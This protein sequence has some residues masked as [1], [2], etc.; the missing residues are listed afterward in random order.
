MYVLL[1]LYAIEQFESK[2][3]NDTV[4]VPWGFPN[5]ESRH[6]RRTEGLEDYW[7]GP[8]ALPPTEGKKAEQF[9]TNKDQNKEL[10][11]P[12]KYYSPG[13]LIVIRLDDAKKTE[14]STS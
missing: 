8:K 4:L 10:N 9:S 2:G 14:T 11:R 3:V 7:H 12:L 13:R 1:Y 6:K 5:V